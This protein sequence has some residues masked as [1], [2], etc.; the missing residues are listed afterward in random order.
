MEKKDI[1]STRD[2]NLATT[3]ITLRYYMQ[4]VDYQV[5]GDRQRMVGYFNFENTPELRKTEQDFWQGKLAVEPRQ[6]I[7]NMR[8]LK[9][10][11]NSVYKSPQTDSSKFKRV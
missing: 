10:Q 11:I 3:L 1:F 4:S 2:L 5:E 8:S 6:F 7:T 9:A